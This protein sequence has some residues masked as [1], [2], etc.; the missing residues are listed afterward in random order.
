M[1]PTRQII[2]QCV[3]QSDSRLGLWPRF[4][5][6]VEAQRVV[7]VGVYKGAFASK[8]LAEC[9]SVVQYYMV[10]PWRRLDNWNKPFN[11]DDSAFEEVLAEA[12]AK[13]AFAA[14]R[15]IILRGT[16][17][18]VIDEIPDGELDYAYIDG[19]HTLRGITIDL[20]RV[21]PKIRQGGWIAADDFCTKIWQ[22]GGGFEPTLVFPF[23]AYFAEAVGATVYA[24][25]DSQCLIEK[26]GGQ[27]FTFIDLTGRYGDTGLRR[28]LRCS[29][30]L[31]HRLAEAGHLAK[32][33]AMRVKHAVF[34]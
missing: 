19:D 31:Q 18:E 32:K 33:L 2:E 5:Q 23:A 8:V 13:T 16:T 29:R 14:D 7:E 10:D 11:V 17:A 24:L 25:P 21:F 22:H 9:D 26:G 34:K 15:R 27:G 4:I 6:Q 28:H 20:I 3:A 1:N 30:L 12:K